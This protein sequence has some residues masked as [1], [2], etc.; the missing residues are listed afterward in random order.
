MRGQIKIL[1]PRQQYV[2]RHS[3]C[4][5]SDVASLVVVQRKSRHFVPPAKY[6]KCSSI[7]MKSPWITHRRR[8]DCKVFQNK[9]RLH[10]VVGQLYHYLRRGV[11]FGKQMRTFG[12]I[13]RL[14]VTVWSYGWMGI[15]RVY[16]IIN[17]CDSQW[18]DL[19]QVYPW[20]LSEG[21]NFYGNA[22]QLGPLLSGLLHW[23]QSLPVGTN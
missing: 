5:M 23:E 14:L 15:S 6:F 21:V 3:A 22:S 1:A 4:R 16:S 17:G 20:V 19:R 10:W 11:L 2:F 7:S 13:F 12:I 18:F 9:P 8:G